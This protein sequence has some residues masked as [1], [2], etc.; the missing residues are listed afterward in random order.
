MVAPVHQAA[1]AV[2]LATLASADRATKEPTAKTSTLASITRARTAA[3]VSPSVAVPL[4]YA[5]V[6]A[7]TREPLVKTVLYLN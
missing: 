6:V 4:T 5:P 2:A 3:P 1:P 7:A